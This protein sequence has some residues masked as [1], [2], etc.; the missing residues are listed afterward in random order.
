MYRLDLEEET[1]YSAKLL[2]N[3]AWLLNFSRRLTS[4]IEA[5]GY[6]G[7]PNDTD[8]R[9]SFLLKKYQ[10]GSIPISKTT[11]RSWF[12]GKSRPYYESRSR[13]RMHELCFALRMDYPSVCRFFTQVYFDRCFNCRSVREA[14]YCYCFSTDQDYMAAIRLYEAAIDFPLQKAALQ[15]PISFTHAMEQDIVSLKTDSELLNYIKEHR[16]SFAEYNQSARR[17]LTRYIE[18]LKGN[19]ADRALINLHRKKQTPLLHADHQKLTGLTVKE[20]FCVH[21][22][23][24]ALKG[25]NVAS[26]DFMLTQILGINLFQYYKTEP[27]KRSFS[28]DASLTE[29][30]RINFPSKQ[31]LS[32]MLKNKDNVSFDAIRKMLILFH[33]Y[34]FFVLLFLEKEAA[35]PYEK[36]DLFLIYTDDANDELADCGYGPLYPENPYDWMFL[37]CAKSECPLDTFRNMILEVIGF[38]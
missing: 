9:V 20:F 34:T 21:D 18:R 24:D 23:C 36:A 7:D 37:Y 2:T 1:L 11:L 15:K 35:F 10:N 33:F 26:S 16:D 14:V 19:E 29:L 22:S 30:A 6:T 4:L 31:V 13:E 25:L 12:S 38:E 32:D 27:G 17:A 8:A 28:K 5:Y 3:P